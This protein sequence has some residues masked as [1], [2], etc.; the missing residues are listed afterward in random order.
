[1]NGGRRGFLMAALEQ[2]AGLLFNFVTVAAVSRFLGPAETG[3]G[4]IGLS[5]TAIVFSLREFASP[6]FLIKIDK[7]R[8]QDIRTSLTFLMSVTVLLSAALYLS[9]GY[10]AETYNDPQLKLFLSITI[11]AALVESLSLPIVALLR[12]EMAFGR[13]ARIRTAGSGLGALV[14]IAMAFCGFGH[15]CFAFGLL[16]SALMTTGLAVAIHPLGTLLRPSLASFD[17]AWRFGIFLGGNAGLNKIC[18]T[19]P[20]LLLGRFMPISAVGIYNRA[21]TLSGLPDR[22]I[23]SAV[24]TVAF[25][26]LS[27]Q[28]REGADISQSYVRALSYITVVYWPAQALLA[29]LAYPAVH[30]VLGPGWSEAAPIVAILSLACLFWFPSI[31]TYPLLMALGQNR[32]AFLSNLISRLVAVTVIGTAAFYGLLAVALGQFISLP[33]QMVIAIVF[34]RRHVAF[35]YAVL[36][37]ALL[38]SGLVTL[39]TLAIPLAMVAAKG[40]SLE[41][42]WSRGVVMGLIAAFS[43]LGAL[44]VVRHP[45]IIE[46]EPILGWLAGKIR[47]RSVHPPASRLAE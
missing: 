31:L 32:E 30:I 38:R 5:L 21:D 8:D 14:T 7:V 33:I 18:M 15:M 11:V 34:V 4:V 25:P 24:F 13:L 23:L 42:H 28:V 9:L 41:I 35:S 3:M 22:I 2:Y 44:F 12:R 40:F 19:L 46:V 27:A 39:I 43:W 47:T 16:A 45:F 10:F 29:L 37:R 6:E 1:M 36:G 17:T 26:M 20:Q